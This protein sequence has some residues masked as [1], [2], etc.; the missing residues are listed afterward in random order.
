MPSFFIYFPLWIHSSPFVSQHFPP[1]LF[2]VSQ[3]SQRERDLS[4]IVF[5][6]RLGHLHLLS[7]FE[8]EKRFESLLSSCCQLE[9]DS[10]LFVHLTLTHRLLSGCKAA[11]SSWGRIRKVVSKILPHLLVADW[12]SGDIVA[13]SWK[14]RVNG[15]GNHAVHFYEF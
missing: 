12:Y 11:N 7:R 6:V 8:M 15:K 2:P 3:S 10:F 5:H 1:L 13:F 9:G 4:I 14:E